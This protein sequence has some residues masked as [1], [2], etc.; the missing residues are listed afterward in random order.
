MSDFPIDRPR[1][2]PPEPGS[3]AQ[4][5]EIRPASHAS[6]DYGPYVA[7][8]R[9]LRRDAKQML[10]RATWIG[11][12]LADDGFYSFPTGDSKVEGP[13]IDLAQ[14]LAQEWGGLIFE[15]ETVSASPTSAG[16]QR[17]HLRARV[18]DLIKVVAVSVDQVVSTSPPPGKFANKADQA[19][20]WHTMQLQSASSKIVRNAILRILPAWYVD[21]ALASAKSAASDNILSGKPLAEVR[22]DVLGAFARNYRMTAAELAAYVDMPVELWVVAQLRELRDLVND[23]RAGRATPDSIRAKLK[24]AE[25]VKDAQLPGRAGRSEARSEPRAPQ[26]ALPDHGGQ[27]APDLASEAERLAQRA[28]ASATAPVPAPVIEEAAPTVEQAPQDAAAI[29][30]QCA[31]LESQLDQIGHYHRVQAARRMSDGFEIE[32]KI[33]DARIQTPRAKRYMESLKQAL[34]D[35]RSQSNGQ[36]TM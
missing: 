19:E 30:R 11:G 13:S 2:L 12:A 35:A 21:A 20:R 8:A 17:V 22:D 1:T 32:G 15:V 5:L 36:E 25:A 34:R 28:P 10:D 31:D 6:T 9:G 26:A 16:G 18:F 4:A 7:A 3:P 24:A 27:P 14:A 23:F 29:K 33:E